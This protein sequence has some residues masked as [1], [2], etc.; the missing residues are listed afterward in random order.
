MVAEAELNCQTR[1]LMVAEARYP[2]PHLDLHLN[3][4]SLM[5]AEAKK[6][7]L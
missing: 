7:D 2:N 5:A 3:P 6:I 4:T 1:H